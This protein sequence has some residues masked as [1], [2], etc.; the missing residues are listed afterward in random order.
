MKKNKTD[1]IKN[2]TEQFIN[3]DPTSGLTLL[4]QFNDCLLKLEKKLKTFGLKND[5]VIKQSIFIKTEN[6]AD[7]YNK[8]DALLQIVKKFYSSF[9]PTTSVIGQP[10]ENGHL[11]ALEVV[12]FK[13]QIGDIKISRKKY[14][15][16]RYVV[17][18]YPDYKEVHAAGICGNDRAAGTFLQAQNTFELM[19][20][21]LE[22]ENLVFSDIVRQWNYIEKITAI[23]ADEDGLKQNYQLFNNVRSKYYETADFKYGYPAATGIGM[24]TGGVIVDFI[25]V[26]GSKNVSIIPIK[27]PLQID[28]HKYSPKVLV[29]NSDKKNPSKTSPKF[30]RAKALAT[31]F[32]KMVF[33]SG[34]AAILGQDTIKENDIT[35]QTITTI[36][37][38]HK[39][40][41][42]DNLRDCGL[43]NATK[44]KSLS[45]IRVYVKHKDDI[46]IVRDICVKYFGD[47]PAL[48]LVSDICRE[49]LLVEIEGVGEFH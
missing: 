28:A 41:S 43:L 12:L 8:K 18:N 3:I 46:K 48:Y 34:T 13:N 15:D 23:N 31:N 19:Q 17:V 9:I 29:G 20:G 10:P 11:I 35:K 26:K 22:K 38:I 49:N 5:N 42:F 39:L 40:I 45:Y 25:A 1:E 21:I 37:N 27:N 47:I 14:S 6:N 2:Y 33:I 36:N 4:E 16:T 7:Y 44:K 32:S 30:E 24:D